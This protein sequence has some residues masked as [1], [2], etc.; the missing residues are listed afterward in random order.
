M[1]RLVRQAFGRDRSRNNIVKYLT[2]DQL[3]AWKKDMLTETAPHEVNLRKYCVLG[4]VLHLDLLEQPPQPRDLR[5]KYVITVCEWINR[6]TRNFLDIFNNTVCD[7]SGHSSRFERSALLRALR[8]TSSSG[9][10]SSK[11]SW[12]N[13][14]WGEETRRGVGET[15]LRYDFVSNFSSLIFYQ[16]GLTRLGMADLKF[17]IPVTTGKNPLST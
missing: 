3:K 5:G 6:F 16:V 1:G 17:K 14:S 12:G 10:R 7:F 8:A 9:T 4:G 15:L 2:E 13:R 11:D